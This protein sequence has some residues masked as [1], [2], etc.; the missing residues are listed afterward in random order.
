MLLLASVQGLGLLLQLES[1]ILTL[2]AQY[3][4]CDL[5]IGEMLSDS[6]R[7]WLGLADEAKQKLTAPSDGDSNFWPL[8]HTNALIWAVCHTHLVI[9]GLL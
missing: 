1:Q 7:C 8:S 2:G 9:F 3:V 5:R 6:D 4:V